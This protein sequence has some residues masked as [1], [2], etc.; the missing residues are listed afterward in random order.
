MLRKISVLFVLLVL[1]VVL[2]AGCS[3]KGSKNDGDAALQ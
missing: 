2:A 3:S 1:V